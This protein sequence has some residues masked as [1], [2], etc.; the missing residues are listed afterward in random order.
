MLEAQG[1]V[2]GTGEP[3]KPCDGPVGH[4]G[5]G[6]AWALARQGEPAG[7]LGDALRM[8]R[9]DTALLEDI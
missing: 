7:N 5:A 3:Q 9:F 8:D 6:R 4:G 2:M 1:G